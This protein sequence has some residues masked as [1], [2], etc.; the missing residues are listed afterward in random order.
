[1]GC[2][3]PGSSV[4]GISQAQIL[5]CVAISSPGDL[6]VP[7]IDPTSTE[8]QAGSLP[9]SHVGR[10]PL[11]GGDTILLTINVCLWKLRMAVSVA[12]PTCKA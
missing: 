9:L 2:S 12:M 8:V 4:H 5:E 1:M 11:S 6:H 7:G 10:L 3:R